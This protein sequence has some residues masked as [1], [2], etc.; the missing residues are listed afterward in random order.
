MLRDDAVVWINGA[1]QRAGASGVSVADH[2]LV[3][4]DGAFETLKIV[5]GVPFAARR[6]IR[7]LHTTLAALAIAAPAE[8]ELRSA[9]AAVVDANDVETGRLRLTVTG[10]PGPLGSGEATGPPTV[11]IA[12]TPGDAPA[13]RRVVTVP[14]VRNERGALTGLKT[15]SYAENVRALRY[16]HEMGAGEALFANTR[17]ELCEGTGSNVFVVVDGE[18]STPPLSSGCLAGITRALVLE[19][20]QVAEQPMPLDVLAEAD[21]VF[22]VST[23]RDVQPIE[24]VDDRTLDAGPTTA[25]IAEAFAAL[26]ERDLDP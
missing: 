1:L 14:W 26:V 24:S 3:V 11:V 22:L 12:V 23:V 13:N 16:A 20:I 21:E 18:V 15:T 5:R 17:D 9:M 19:L 6:H 8:D 25:A 4:G 7:R 2:G 10:G